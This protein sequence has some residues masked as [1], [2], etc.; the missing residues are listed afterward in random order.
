MHLISTVHIKNYRSISDH[1][2]PLSDFT[3]LV[4]YNNA[5]KTNILEAVNWLAKKSSLDVSSFG[6]PSQPI[7][8]TAEISGIDEGVLDA[9]GPAHRTKIE[10]LVV[11]G[12]IVIRRIQTEPGAKAADI[13]LAI[14]KCDADGNETWSNPAGIDA[15]AWFYP[16]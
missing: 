4:G 7:V 2:F 16:G 10:P 1:Q 8:V 5:G 9:L 12:M 3:A 11:D 13:K 14:H 6:N 15:G